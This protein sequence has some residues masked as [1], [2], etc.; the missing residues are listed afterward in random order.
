ML[1]AIGLSMTSVI[2]DK[3]SEVQQELEISVLTACS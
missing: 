3:D 1:I 2:G